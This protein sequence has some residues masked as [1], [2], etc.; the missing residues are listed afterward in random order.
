MD[1]REYILQKEAI[2]AG[3][4]SIEPLLILDDEAN[5]II[6]N[7][8]D[9]R[10]TEI[11]LELLEYMAKNKI[12]LDIVNGEVECYLSNGERISKEQLFENFI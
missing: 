10:A 6:F 12:E 3:Y 2:K 7:A 5:K 8:M 9:D 4:A 11:C 1:R